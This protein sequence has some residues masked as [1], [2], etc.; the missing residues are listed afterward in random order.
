MSA[1]VLTSFTCLLASLVAAGPASSCMHLQHHQLL[2]HCTKTTTY[3]RTLL[4][5][6]WAGVLLVQFQVAYRSLVPVFPLPQ[7]ADATGQHEQQPLE[8]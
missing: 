7:A 1:V 8:A 3:F 2:K 4:Q 6:V 5:W